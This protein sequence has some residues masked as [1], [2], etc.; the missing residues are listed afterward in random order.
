MPISQVLYITH[1]LFLDDILIFCDGSHKDVDKL[2]QGID[3]F[4]RASGM[5]LNEDKSF[6]T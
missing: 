6:V 4:K 3:L 2:S 1:L 5:I